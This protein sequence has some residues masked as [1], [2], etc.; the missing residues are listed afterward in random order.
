ML[1]GKMLT[2]PSQSLAG[3]PLSSLRHTDDLLGAQA[4]YVTMLSQKVRIKKVWRGAE[5]LLFG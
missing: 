1:L 4:L 2:F 3:L 5:G